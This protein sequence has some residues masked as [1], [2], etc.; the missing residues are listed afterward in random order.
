MYSRLFLRSRYREK[1]ATEE[2]HQDSNGK[3]GGREKSAGD[4]IRDDEKDRAGEGGDRKQANVIGAEQEACDVG[5]NESR[6]TDEAPERHGDG[7]EK[8]ADEDDKNTSCFNADTELVRIL[9]AEC[10]GIET[11]HEGISR[12]STQRQQD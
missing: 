5:N 11:T 9:V 4:G 2:G 3:F 12:K 7:S 8:R 10:E 1:R 6:E